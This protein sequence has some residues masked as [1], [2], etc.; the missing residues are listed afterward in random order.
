MRCSRLF[1]LF[2]LTT[3]APLL[4]LD[5]PFEATPPTLRSGRSGAPGTWFTHRGSTAFTSIGR[6][7]LRFRVSGVLATLDM[8][9][10]DASPG[11][12]PVGRDG[13]GHGTYLDDRLPGGVQVRS[14]FDRVVYP[15]VWP[16]IDLV[17]YRRD[18][19]IVY[20]LLLEP[21]AD[22]DEVCFRFSGAEEL[23]IDSGGNLCIDWAGG[24][25][26]HSAPRCF[27]GRGSEATP[28][29]GRFVLLGDHRVGFAV[30]S[31]EDE[32]LR[33]DPSIVFSSYF[34]ALGNDNLQDVRVDVDGFVTVSGQ[35]T[36]AESLAFDPRFLEGDVF[37]RQSF[38]ARMSPDGRRLL[39]GVFLDGTG[40]GSVVHAVDQDGVLHVGGW[41][42]RL[43]TTPDA[44]QSEGGPGS[45]Y[46]AKI[47][48]SGRELLYASYLTGPGGG[49]PSNTLRELELDAEGNAYLL[50]GTSGE[51]ITQD[52]AQALFGGVTDC[53]LTKLRADGRTV[54]Y[55][56]HIGGSG[57]D[58]PRGLALHSD[59][60]ALV[61][62]ST[63]SSDFPL[64]PAE[65]RP[66][67]GPFNNSTHV[68]VRL[69]PSGS[70]RYAAGFETA[71]EDGTFD[72]DGRVFL[73][74]T[75]DFN[76]P[77]RNAIFDADTTGPVLLSLNDAGTEID[78]ATPLRAE[79]FG[80]NGTG[81]DLAFDE[82]GNLLIACNVSLPGSTG[83][84]LVDPVQVDP[85]FRGRED[86]WLGLLAADFEEH[87]P[88]AS[89]DD[90]EG[91]FL[92]A[93]F[94]G[95]DRTESDSSA[96]TRAEALDWGAEGH[97]A[98]AGVAATPL[99]ATTPEDVLFPVNS[100]PAGSTASDSF[101]TV[102]DTRGSTPS[103]DPVFLV[104][105]EV[106]FETT[107]A[108]PWA[109][110]RLAT[111]AGKTLVVEAESAGGDLLLSARFRRPATRA[112]F[113][114]V[115][116]EVEPA[117]RHLVI[118]HSGSG[119]YSL[120]VEALPPMTASPVRLIAREVDSYVETSSAQRALTGETFTTTVTGAGFDSETRFVLTTGGQDPILNDEAETSYVGPERVDVVFDLTGAAAGTWV[121]RA[122]DF[123]E[124]VREGFT[125]VTIVDVASPLGLSVRLE[126]AGSF[127]SGVP[128]PM[129]LVVENRGDRGV[130]PPLLTIDS[131]AAGAFELSWSLPGDAEESHDSIQVLPPARSGQIAAGET[132]RVPLFVR[133]SR[134]EGAPA[135][136][137]GVEIL[138]GH[139]LAGEEDFVPYHALESLTDQRGLTIR[140]LEGAFGMRW[141]DYEGRLQRAAARRDRMGDNSSS[142]QA[143]FALAYQQE[144]LLQSGLGRSF[145]TGQLINEFTGAPVAGS[146]I[147]VLRAGEV[148]G[149]DRTERDGR[150]R[151]SGLPPGEFTLTCETH[152]LPED[153]V[154]IP[155][156]G[157]DGVPRDLTGLRLL[158][159]RRRPGDAVVRIAEEP[160]PPGPNLRPLRLPPEVHAEL[161]IQTLDAGGSVDPNEKC[162]P[163]G[164]PDRDPVPGPD[165]GA[166]VSVQ[167]GGL[168][169]A[170]EPA[171]Y[172][173]H[174]ENLPDATRSAQVVRIEDPLGETF[175]LE[176]FRP[177]SV[178]LA[179]QSYAFPSNS[180]ASV[181]SPSASGTLGSDRLLIP[182]ASDSGRYPD[183]LVACDYDRATGFVGVEF[184]TW[185]AQTLTEPPKSDNAGFLP[186]DTDGSRGRGSF[187]FTAAPRGTLRG[188]IV[189][190][191]RVAIT[192]DPDS[193]EAVTL[194]A[195]AWNRIVFLQPLELAE[196]PIFPPDAL[197][198][199][200]P[201]NTV[202]S[203]APSPRRARY[204]ISLWEV[205]ADVAPAERPAGLVPLLRDSL[206]TKHFVRLSEDRRYRWQV[207]ARDAEGND[208]VSPAWVFR[209]QARAL[210]LPE[211]PVLL[212]PRDGET[213]HAVGA[214]LEWSSAIGASAYRIS[215]TPTSGGVGG[216][217]S[218]LVETSYVPELSPETDYEWRV[219]ALN[220]RGEASS[221]LATFRT[222]ARSEVGFL[223]G[224]V[225]FDE[226]RNI[227]D[228]IVVLSYLFLGGSV[229]GC[230]DA[231]DTD[232]TGRLDLSDAV[233]LLNF[234]FLGGATPPEPGDCGLD[235]TDDGLSCAEPA[236]A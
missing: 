148:V 180:S 118:P 188:G 128:H 123:G 83:L 51:W 125:L 78:F 5:W 79:G 69:E 73:T 70:L 109:R 58:N 103:T 129:A 29:K 2:I 210:A 50:G 150:F 163:R 8:H 122:A 107:A 158:G 44:L 86:V 68:V 141:T 90:T 177:L 183:V 189:H 40:S 36:G 140:L 94:L 229:P 19:E 184:R 172:T 95:G 218:G 206:E 54:V 182:E 87:I 21:G 214:A 56:T 199:A 65:N 4:A 84:P 156:A 45:I 39:F 223:R 201:V 120:R 225:N 161:A 24:I 200:V 212:T 66:H 179:G 53:F 96:S 17:L 22:P 233:Y 226:D 166:A 134:G 12:V 111:E 193:S 132:V 76:F 190:P 55:S 67:D 110:Y 59:G 57:A 195:L 144:R 131:A 117:F 217:F 222:S 26:R 124:G 41:S 230:L 85:H 6:D 194:E 46:L 138:L 81:V 209:T 154:V 159:R 97:L 175:D 37:F 167:R 220:S 208:V 38:V 133:A 113:D 213:E 192:F 28:V 203:F 74:G 231:A 170:G 47:D 205:D 101:V 139:L 142:V 232:D 43:P 31:P 164:I 160:P 11:T 219:T 146:K 221:E 23:R 116:V 178:S 207:T 91:V 98:L 191:N 176:S 234:L 7:S 34:G 104:G 63:D 14:W 93:S 112:L 147:A 152:R 49:S 162:P 197:S 61:V 82:L 10:E 30:D 80:G 25:V 16:G 62:L 157:P 35:T 89:A 48:P 130:L 168:I 136:E 149:V 169:P 99:F 174:F 60:S 127:R 224:D 18:G 228:A 202:L 13:A 115:G 9:L 108:Q 121:L 215:W 153:P 126:G 92:F 3:P 100:G 155:A 20:D 52:A 151:I 196:T 88:L 186:P 227:S 181:S 236:C 211:A 15:D 165:P 32:S 171:V 33:I 173:V 235:P 27:R 145:L 106:I 75:A 64:L 204:T 105:E 77:R 135:G 72:A 185:D 71:L 114:H 1:A 216:E 143:A 137:D 187:T 198:S 119:I 42:S 102:I